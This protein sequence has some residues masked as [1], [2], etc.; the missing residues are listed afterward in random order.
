MTR[1][2]PPFLGQRRR[3]ILAL[4]IVLQ[5]REV[6]RLREWAGRAPERSGPGV[7]AVSGRAVGVPELEPPAAERGA[8]EAALAEIQTDAGQNL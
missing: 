4:L 3:A 2:E 8:R 6:R 1:D 5:A 7:T